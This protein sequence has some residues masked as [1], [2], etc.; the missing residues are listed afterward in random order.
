MSAVAAPPRCS[1]IVPV[2]GNEGTIAALLDAVDDLAATAPGGLEAV[3]VVDG[4]PDDSEAVLRKLLPEHPYPSTLLVHSRNFGSFPAIRTGLGVARGD[5]LAVMAADLQEPPELI[6]TFFER[7]DEGEHELVIGVRAGRDDPGASKAASGLFWKL[8][9][10]IVQPDMPEGGVDVFGCSSAV[11]D[12]LLD[13]RESHGSLV[14]LLVWMGY[15]RA[16]IPYQ[17]LART[18]G[19]SGWTMKKK[20]RYMS[21]SIF[22]FTDLPIR[23][24]MAVGL[25]GSI[26]ALLAAAA[27]TIA[28]RFGDVAVPGYTPL[29]LATLLVGTLIL[30]GLGVV[31]SYVWRTYENTKA[32]PLSLVRATHRYPGTDT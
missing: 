28:W 31:G 4:S 13:M 24:L 19:K 6:Q 20:L 8:Y 15:P 16:E 14:G 22:S 17:R 18:V 25:I 26:S 1:L 12:V 23:L 5:H 11:R 3:F 29:M 32:R 2:Y 21:D 9:R 27:I 30:L 10:R 7:L